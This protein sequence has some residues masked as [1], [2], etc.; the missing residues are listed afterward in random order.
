VAN[1]FGQSNSENNQEIPVL[2]IHLDDTSVHL[3][4]RVINSLT[5]FTLGASL[6]QYFGEKDASLIRTV[7]EVHPEVCIIDLDRDRPMALET[8]EYLRRTSVNPIPIFAVSTRMEPEA[9]IEAMRSGCT[10]YLE[11]PLLSDRVQEALMQVARKKRD[12]FVSSVQGRLVTLMGVKG[13]VGTT[14]L[15]VHLA[16]SLAKRDKK[17]LLVDHHPEL[18]EVTLH[19]GL[20]HHNYGF[21]ELACN[22]SRMDA[23]LLQGFV[24][25][26]ESGLEVLASP[27]SLGMTPKTTPEAIQHTLRFLLRMYDYVIVDTDCRLDEQNLAMVELSDEFCL[28]ATPQ[29]PAVRGTSRFLDYLLR[30]NFPVSKS[31]VILNRWT[32]RAPLSVENI[33]KALHRKISLIIPNCDQELGEAIATGIPVSVKSRSDFM[34]GIGK[35]TMRLNGSHEAPPGNTIDKRIH[36][37]RSRFNVLGISG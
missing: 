36:Q 14:T 29:L 25:K 22:L 28:I 6:R 27:E 7:R 23:E 5:G 4:N 1:T 12:S 26:H 8:V 24:L 3:L 16:Y 15:A 32:K 20:E 19:L 37:A 33:E 10:E 31:Q 2:A 13:G 35:W 17:V 9:I 18:G 30:L 11:K 21:Y 34:Q